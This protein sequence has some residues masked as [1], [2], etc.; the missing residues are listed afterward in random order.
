MSSDVLLGLGANVGDREGQ[1]EE[2]ISR[3]GRRGFVATSR[4]SLYLTE[5]VD[6]PPQEWFVN[7]AVAGA[8]ALSP[9]ELLDACLS[10]EREL[11]R[12]RVIHRGPRT[13]DLDLLIFGAEVR[14]TAALT[15]P[16]P[17]LHERR[18][19]LVPAAEIAPALRHPRLG[20]TLAE[21]LAVCPDPAQVRWHRGP[22]AWT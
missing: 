14:Q 3:L 7:G 10:V 13:V 5:P 15:L 22:E 9:E 21:L 8:T 11:G 16:H 6:A 17:R 19:V 1:L 2:A 20:R 4:S 18:F 12:E